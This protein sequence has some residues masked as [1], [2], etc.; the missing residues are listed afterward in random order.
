MMHRHL[1][2]QHTRFLLA[3]DYLDVSQ[4]RLIGRINGWARFNQ[5]QQLVIASASVQQPPSAF[6]DGVLAGI[7]PMLSYA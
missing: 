4:D 2:P 7:Q 6:I 5:M 3:A 1:I